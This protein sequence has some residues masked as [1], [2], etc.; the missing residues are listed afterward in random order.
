MTWLPWAEV[1]PL[2]GW[3]LSLQAFES[4]MHKWLLFEMAKNTQSED[5]AIPAEKGTGDGAAELRRV[6]EVLASHREPSPPPLT[7][8][9][10]LW[11]AHFP[12]QSISAQCL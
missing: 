12:S 2:M 3:T 4:W 6:R 5:K 11:G 1:S 10:V 9:L 7:D 8:L